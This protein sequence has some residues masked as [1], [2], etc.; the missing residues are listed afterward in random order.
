[1]NPEHIHKLILSSST[2]CRFIRLSNAFI[3]PDPETHYGWMDIQK[4]VTNLNFDC[5]CVLLKHHHIV[6]HFSYGFIILIHLNSSFLSYVIKYGKHNLKTYNQE[7]VS[8]YKKN[9]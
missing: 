2:S 9:I 6:N 1:M 7:N 8:Y 4:F 5:L 3:F